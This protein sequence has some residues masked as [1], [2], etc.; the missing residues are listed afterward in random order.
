M[1]IDL[2]THST[3]SDGSLRPAEL[4][5]QAHDAG[6]NALALTDHDTVTGL[7]EALQAGE[8]A[9]LEVIPGCEL[10]VVSPA[11]KMHILGLWLPVNPTGLLDSLDALV[12]HRHERN[13]IIVEKLQQLGLDITYDEVRERAGEGSVG[14]PHIAGIL[15]DKGYVT[16]VQE[17]FTRFLGP[18]GK[19]YVP[20]KVLTAAEAVTL[21]KNEGATVMM[22]HPFLNGL[23]LDQV[24]TECIRLR[25]YGMDGFE[26][27][28]SEHSPSQQQALLNLAGRLE[29][30][31]S[32]GSDFHGTPKPNI[33]L[34]VGKGGLNI[35]DSVLDVLK[36]YRL[37]QGLRV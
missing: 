23:N 9:G 1:A 31:V 34:G 30:Q 29:M 10:S 20:K 13:I 6:L 22:A 5:Q 21:L 28:Y 12:R 24:A 7:K 14:R 37:A 19:A 2:H 25:E 11:A 35:P 8:A 33:R 3:A 16:S 18:R 17:S 26:A 15:F 4:V 32:G 27:Y 36:E